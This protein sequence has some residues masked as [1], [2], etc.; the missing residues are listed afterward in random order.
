[1]AENY[2]LKDFFDIP[3]VQR[4][5]HDVQKV[6]KPFPVK[7]FVDQIAKTLPDLELKE[8]A[9]LIASH[10]Y[11]CLPPAYPKALDIL[12][13]SLQQADME[14]SKSGMSG[15]YFMPHSLYVAGYGMDH[16][17]LSMQALYEITQRFTSE[18][19]IR[20]FI[21]SYPE[22]TLQLLAQWASDPNEHVRR[23]VSEGTRPRLPWA[24]RL[25]EFQKN[26]EPVLELLEMLRA[27]PSEYVRRSVANNLNDIAKDH[28][29]RVI[30]VCNRWMYE[31]GETARALCSHALRGL[32]K[33]GNPAALAAL[34]VDHDV[35]AGAGI[36]TCKTEVRKGDYLVFEVEVFSREK[37]PASLVIEYVIH[38]LKANAKHST[39]VFRLAKEEFGPL[40]TKRYTRRK[41]FV[42]FTTRTHYPGTHF[43]EIQVNGKRYG[44]QAFEVVA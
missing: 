42:D 1:M 13:R 8:R 6:W 40:E 21:L 30:E 39:K 17:D 23:L 14:G 9:G 11:Q 36:L 31:I 34:G 15:F 28:P 43:L 4:I 25:P 16:F 32:I 19:A 44:K 5:A 35:S 41:Q 22:R 29:Q 18:F 37:E 2:K 3:L 20:P 24:M 27:D 7:D 38:Y 26:P 12:V 10:L 33:A